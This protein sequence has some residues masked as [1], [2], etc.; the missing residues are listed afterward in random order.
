M[1]TGPACTTVARVTAV[2]VHGVLETRI[3]W[4][5]VREGLQQDSVAVSLPGFGAPLPD[6]FGA[7]KD[8]YAE[9]L[10]A[11]VDRLDGPVDLVGHSFGGQLCLR[12][13]T[14]LGIRPRSWAVDLANA[15]HPRYVWHRTAR[16][17]Q[18]PGAGE[19]SLARVRADGRNGPSRG[20]ARLEQLGFPSDAAREMSVAHDRTMSECILRIYRSAQPNLRAEWRIEAAVGSIAP[21]L[22]LHAAADPFGDESMADEVGAELG[23][24]K[25]RLDDLGHSWMLED[26][27]RVGAIL[28]RFWASL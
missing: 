11:E 20:E 25:V 14:G 22:V 28:E 12:L 17:W 7:T 6:G 1:W 24:A 26:P 9:W 23:A 3:V 2:F 18:T 16:I 19:E 5:A 13:V 10:A 15:F 27:E 21:G 8:D 4:D